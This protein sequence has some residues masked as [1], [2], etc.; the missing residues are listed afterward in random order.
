MWD[1][2]W[3]SAAV[4]CMASGCDPA[5]FMGYA[6][7]L[8]D[9]VPVL[10]VTSSVT[11]DYVSE[12]VS[13][14]E[15]TSRAATLEFNRVWAEGGVIVTEAQS[16]E[17]LDAFRTLIRCVSLGHELPAWFYVLAPT[18][19]D[20]KVFNMW[21]DDARVEFTR[22]TELRAFAREVV[23]DRFS[24]LEAKWSRFYDSP[25]SVPVYPTPCSATRVITGVDVTDDGDAPVA[26]DTTD[27]ASA[28]E[29]ELVKEWDTEDGVIAT[30]TLDDPPKPVT[31][32]P[33]TPATPG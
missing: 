24:A 21:G 28:L 6:L 30:L 4:A 7:E 31:V 20:E 18:A 9:E 13:E 33:A 25:V 22:S 15:A 26:E 29:L 11:A 27:F 16:S 10:W 32:S 8:A 23:P 17:N 19:F 5:T 3:N 12:R 14:A 2:A 1:S